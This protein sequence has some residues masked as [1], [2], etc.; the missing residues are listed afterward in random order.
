MLLYKRKEEVNLNENKRLLVLLGTI[1]LIIAIILV[2]AL[3][4]EPDT[5]FACGVKADKEYSKLGNVNYEQYECLKEENNK[6]ALAVSDGLSDKE[7]EAINEAAKEMNVEV[8][9]LS[10]ELSNSDLKAIKK[11]LKT[12]LVSY[13]D[14]SLVVI[15]NGKVE[16]GTDKKLNNSDEVFKFFDKAGL[17]IFACNTE[18]DSEYENLA[19]L[20]YEQYECLYEG[21]KP[22]VMIVTQSTCG[23]CQEFL[24]VINEYAGKNHLPA[25]ILEIDTMDSDDVNN[26]LSS[27]SYFEENTGWGTP[28]TLAIKD[29]KVI[30]ELSGYTD[31]TT[32]IENL[33]KELELK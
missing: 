26:I 17:A 5:T 24:P 33:Y 6:Y 18:A 12:D 1:I 28:L 13:D 16:F 25:Y 7:K 11:E 20:T 22:F 15:E 27:L 14:S 29:K 4:P 2:I 19:K 30:T 23:Y 3:W 10:D 8:Y 32:S 9:Y 21:N 31:D